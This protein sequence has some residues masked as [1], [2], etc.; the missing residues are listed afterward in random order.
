MERQLL[1][2][3]SVSAAAKGMA[4][5]LLCVSS[6]HSWRYEPVP[7]MQRLPLSEGRFFTKFVQKTFIINL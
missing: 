6:N 2:A 5:W 3:P 7:G 1:K 4:V